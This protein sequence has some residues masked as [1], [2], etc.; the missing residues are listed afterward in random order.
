MV[1]TFL[2]VSTSVRQFRL[3]VCLPFY[4]ISDSR[5]VHPLD[6]ITIHPSVRIVWLT[7]KPSVRLVILFAELYSSKLWTF[8]PNRKSRPDFISVLLY[9]FRSFGSMTPIH[10]LNMNTAG[11]MRDVALFITSHEQD[12]IKPNLHSV[13]SLFWFGFSRGI[14]FFRI[15]FARDVKWWWNNRVIWSNYHIIHVLWKNRF[16]LSSRPSEWSNCLFCL[17][18]LAMRYKRAMSS[19]RFVFF[20]IRYAYF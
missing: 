15:F 7:V 16:I 19:H 2:S 4:Y 8:L 1:I 10:L 5:L 18:W 11:S 20:I 9:F 12:S 14:D 17:F 3:S 6:C 13:I